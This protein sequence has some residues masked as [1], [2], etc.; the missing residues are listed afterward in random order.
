MP[1][2]T[3]RCIRNKSTISLGTKQPPFFMYFV[4]FMMDTDGWETIISIGLLVFQHS[5][6][7]TFKSDTELK[8]MIIVVEYF[9]P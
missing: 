5:E 1:L 7:D 9:D 3:P 8:Y 4:F 6:K 2:I